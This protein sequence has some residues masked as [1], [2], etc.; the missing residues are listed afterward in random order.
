VS[1]WVASL[2]KSTLNSLKCLFRVAQRRIEQVRRLVVSLRV[3]T[4]RQKLSYGA[5]RI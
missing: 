5:E 3:A 1:A 4:S 2:H